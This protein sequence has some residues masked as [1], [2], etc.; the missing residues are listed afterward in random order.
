VGHVAR[1]GGKGRGAYRVLVGR[2]ERRRPLGRPRRRWEMKLKGIWK[3][4][5][6]GVSWIDLAQDT[7]NLRA[8]ANTAM[9]ILFLKMWRISRTAEESLDFQE[10]L[11]SVTLVR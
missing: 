6:G 4:Y 9:K 11:R 7:E 5:D 8:L 2:P 3:E 10:G 1:I